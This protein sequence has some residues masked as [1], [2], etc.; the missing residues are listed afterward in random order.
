[1]NAVDV[2]RQPGEFPGGNSYDRQFTASGARWLSDIVHVGSVT[3]EVFRYT[4]ISWYI[5]LF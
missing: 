1:V 2:E 4:A 3:Y 5:S